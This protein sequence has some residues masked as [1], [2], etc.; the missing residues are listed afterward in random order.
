MNNT[1]HSLKN[2]KKITVIETG[3]GTSNPST[4]TDFNHNGQKK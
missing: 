2:L 4:F 1:K 3:K